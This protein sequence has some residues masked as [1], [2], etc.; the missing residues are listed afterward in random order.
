MGGGFESGSRSIT[1]ENE[2]GQGSGLER[3]LSGDVIGIALGS[4]DGKNYFKFTTIN[5]ISLYV[6]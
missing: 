6:F 2:R 3:A 5:L 4:V 1:K